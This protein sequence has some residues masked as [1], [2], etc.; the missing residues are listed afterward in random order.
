[1]KKR[2]DELL[3]KYLDN[4]LDSSELNEFSEILERDEETVKGLKAMKAVEQSVRKIE[5]ESAPADI[6]FKVMRKIAS[7]K[8]VK[9]SNWFFWVVVSVFLIAIAAV[10]YYS[11]QQYTPSPEG[12]G[13]GK[14]VETVKTFFGDQTK[15]FNS[16]LKGVDI[17]FIG[18]V[19]TL[20]I[21]IAGYFIFET[22][23]NFKN[24]LKSLTR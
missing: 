3:N 20:L 14:T 21:I 8:S 18:T 13:A 22:H 24:K 12:I 2:T 4:E 7:A 11:V 1:M 17:K 15:A 9:R 16:I 5:F 23:R 19:L 6:T 10:T